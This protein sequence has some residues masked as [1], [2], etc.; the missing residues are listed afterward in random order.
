MHYTHTQT[1]TYT[2]TR[3]DPRQHHLSASQ[4]QECCG[5]VE[6]GTR[7][8]LLWGERN[9]CPRTTVY[10][11]PAYYYICVLILLCMCP[12]TSAPIVVVE[13]APIVVVENADE[14]LNFLKMKRILLYV[15]SYYYICVLIPL[16]MCPHR[17]RGRAGDLS[18]D[19]ASH[20]QL[21]HAAPLCLLVTELNLCLL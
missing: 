1:H 6:A 18:E 19:E 3:I 5:G 7:L 9:I 2:H 17:E 10:P 21:V 16:C 11:A 15:S 13:N 4:Q 14:L 8:M 12:H 20:L